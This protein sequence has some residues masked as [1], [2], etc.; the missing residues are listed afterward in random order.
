[1]VTPRGLGRT[2]PGFQDAPGG[3]TARSRVILAAMTCCSGKIQNKST[4][5]GRGNARLC[6]SP[7]ETSR[8]SQRLRGARGEGGTNHKG[9]E[10]T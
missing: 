7:E 9:V 6:C 3:L 2:N 8:Q 5:G 10:E 1:M 4:Q